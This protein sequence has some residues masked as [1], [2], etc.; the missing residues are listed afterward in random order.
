M[1]SVFSSQPLV[2]PLR[3]PNYLSQLV[4]LPLPVLSYAKY[5]D[6][7]SICPCTSLA[8]IDSPEF[9]VVY[10]TLP[11]RVL[12]PFKSRIPKCIVGGW[13]AIIQHRL[14]G[15]GCQ[16][17]EPG[18]LSTLALYTKR[19]RSARY[20][21]RLFPYFPSINPFDGNVYFYNDRQVV[22]V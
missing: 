13:L 18:Q 22:R 14:Y 17:L 16:Y 10:L 2:V 8:S 12:Y 3:A 9:S 6:N 1:N 19:E 15:R 4:I 20:P 21:Y 7:G 5:P 11:A